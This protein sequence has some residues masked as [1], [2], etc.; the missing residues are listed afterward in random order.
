MWFPSRVLFSI[1]TKWTMLSILKIML[2]YQRNFLMHKKKRETKRKKL[3][4][5]STTMS[6]S[7]SLTLMSK[8]FSSQNL[9]LKGLG[10]SWLISPSTTTSCYRRASTTKADRMV[11]LRLKPLTTFTFKI[12]PCWARKRLTSRIRRPLRPLRTRICTSVRIISRLN[13]SSAIH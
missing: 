9:T 12:S 5:R 13:S 11:T 1:S 3:N 4:S 6:I 7:H 8:P 10:L 2:I